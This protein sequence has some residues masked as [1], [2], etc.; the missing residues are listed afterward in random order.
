[1]NKSVV[2]RDLVLLINAQSLN[3]LSWVQQR[4]VQQRAIQRIRRTCSFKYCVAGVAN[5]QLQK[6]NKKQL[7]GIMIC[8]KATFLAFWSSC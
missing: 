2:H 1:M 3:L 4:A 7:N 6:L 5:S 8:A